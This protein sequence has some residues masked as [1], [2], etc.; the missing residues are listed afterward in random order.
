M[1]Q[2]EGTKEDWTLSSLDT[3]LRIRDFNILIDPEADIDCDCIDTKYHI[4]GIIVFLGNT[5]KERKANTKL[6]RSAPELLE[7]CQ[8]MYKYFEEKLESEGLDQKDRN[9]IKGVKKALN[10]AL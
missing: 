4:A 3:N 9:A 1:K 5:V 6:V 7:A 2:F 8:R 10:K